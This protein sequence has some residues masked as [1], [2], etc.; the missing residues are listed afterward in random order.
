MG[1]ISY[2]WFSNKFSEYYHLT[3]SNASLEVYPLVYLRLIYS[4]LDGTSNC[5]KT[6]FFMLLSIHLSLLYLSPYAAYNE[7][8][9]A[10][11]NKP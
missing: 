6:D 8:L 10:S 7:L 5:A 9:T 11:L 1:S 2:N 3:S 4:I